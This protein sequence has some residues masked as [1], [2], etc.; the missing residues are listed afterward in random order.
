[1]SRHGRCGRGAGCPGDAQH[2]R[3]DDR[4]REQRR[5][6]GD[7]LAAAAR[8]PVVVAPLHARD[9]LRLDF[10][11]VVPS[12]EAGPVFEICS[13]TRASPRLTR[14]RTTSSEQTSSLAISR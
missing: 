14:L 12:H 7:E 10:V 13:R 1:V 11:Q 2:N 9:E 5:Q 3:D 6:H 8:A 4:R